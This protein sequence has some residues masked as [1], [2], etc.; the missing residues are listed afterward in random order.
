MLLL[1]GSMLAYQHV[2][3]PQLSAGC[4]YQMTC[5]NYAKHAIGQFGAIRGVLLTADRLTRC[6]RGTVRQLPPFR[7]APNGKAIDEP[8]IHFDQ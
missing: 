1:K 6:N 3:S 7:F 5:S 4:L 8:R 2:I